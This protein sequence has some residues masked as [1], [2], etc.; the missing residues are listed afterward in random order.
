MSNVTPMMKQYL[1]IK[2]EHKDAFLFFRLGDFYEL[3]YD[4]AVEAA[5]L[6]EI[7][8]TSRDKTSNIPMAG[9]PYHSATRYIEKLINHGYK[10]AICEQME[11][12]K[13]VKGMVKREVVRV[14]T[15]GTLI[16]DF[17]ISQDE[18]NYILSLNHRDDIYD[19]VYGDISTGDMYSFETKD[20]DTLYTQLSRINPREIVVSN[21]SEAVLHNFYNDPPLI[22]VVDG[23]SSEVQLLSYIESQNKQKLSHLKD[24]IEINVDSN[25]KLSQSTISNLELVENLQTKKQKGSL[26]W[27]LNKTETPMGR[28]KLKRLI[29]SPL[30]NLEEIKNRQDVVG[31]LLE[32]FIEREDIKAA[33]NNV[34]DI[35]RLTG[36]M[37]FGNIDV[38][39]F[40]ELR[41]S[42]EGL[43]NVYKLLS[44]I[45]LIDNV[46]FKD[47]DVLSDVYEMLK[48]LKSDAP[49]T[50]REGNIFEYG[51]SKEL[52]E[53]RDIQN[54][55]REWLENYLS[56]E[57]E[58]TNIKNMKIGFNKVF[59]Y[60]LE[61]SKGQAATF[62]AEKYGYDRRQTL[63]N[64]ERY[65]TP[66]LKE[67][68][69]KIL[70]A[71]DESVILEYNM[72]IDLREKVKGHTERLQRTSEQLSILD[73]LISFADV[74]NEYQ[75][76]RPEFTEDELEIIDG[77]HPIV[78]KMLGERTYV[79]NDVKMDDD[80][81]IYLITG[82]NMSGKST[83]MRQVAIITI[84]SQ[85]GM[86][87]PAASCKIPIFD[88]IY[89]RIGAS[90][91]LSSGK[92][93]FMIEM[94]EAN[95]ALKH[96]TKNSLIIFDELGRGTS[97][98]DG[99]ALAEAML[100]Y[101]HNY[102][103]AKTLFSTHYHELTDLDASLHHL[104]NVHVKAS[105]KNGVLEF[106]HK[107]E[108][109]AVEKSYGI[110]VA[111]LADLPREVTI[112]ARKVLK[113]L[114]N[115]NDNTVDVTQLELTL[116]DTSE[117]TST[118]EEKIKT[119][120]INHISPIEAL[121]LLSEFQDELK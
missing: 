53:L 80:T 51:V 25:L 83:Y 96:A 98:Y 118:I 43:P 82:P 34:Y 72:F 38:K 8:L 106:Q 69:D 66:E 30:V 26:Y 41:D 91:D 86:N 121:T 14:I 78:E 31:K 52:D 92:S 113:R 45:G 23:T 59:G 111:E 37:S 94:M 75:L 115:T 57:K 7:T 63:T 16:D 62:D 88:A 17:G 110:Q 13:A 77:R 42:L 35:E 73:C 6:L 119:L 9:V 100:K 71:E 12:P 27:Y 5:K 120:N 112:E 44:S 58:K 117:Q 109:G 74:S 97:T 67:M 89:T 39:G 108:K 20:L 102:I 65:I 84:M 104:M 47:F 55:S 68:E 107:V 22:T 61:I 28:R 49:K 54:N 3:F 33:L 93:T 105:E 19:V 2:E 70:K 81:F 1:S 85:I 114:E 116:D 90:D 48:V 11:D 50:I 36:R 32:N 76:V 21:N 101:I 18:S 64:S 99:M 46:L 56:K 87:V 60:F 95:D 10:V 29:E 15:P 103:G 4:D 79:P 40:I 24:I